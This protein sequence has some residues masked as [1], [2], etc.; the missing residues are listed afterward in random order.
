MHRTTT[1]SNP[2]G[3]LKKQREQGDGGTM[4][5]HVVTTS[6]GFTWGS[7]KLGK[8]VRPLEKDVA[9]ELHRERQLETWT[10][11]WVEQQ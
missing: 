7:H 2:G 9:L 4:T 1:P 8:S 10:Y 5:L 3:N 6:M 11:G